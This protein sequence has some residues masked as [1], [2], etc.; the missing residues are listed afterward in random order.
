MVSRNCQVV[1]PLHS[2]VGE[3]GSLEVCVS[4]YGP[5]GPM[6]GVGRGVNPTGICLSP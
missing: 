3:C 6:R 1:K 2:S 5:T 4:D